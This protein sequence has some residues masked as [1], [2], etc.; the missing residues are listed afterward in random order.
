V[1]TSLISYSPQSH[2]VLDGI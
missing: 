2:D 1:Y